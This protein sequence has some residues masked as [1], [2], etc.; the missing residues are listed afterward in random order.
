MNEQYISGH[1]IA[2]QFDLSNTTLRRW[3][4]E[5]KIRFLRT[6][7]GKGKRIYH[8]EDVKAIVGIPN[9]GIRFR[10]TICYARVSSTHQKEDLLRQ[11]ETLSKA[12]PQAEIVSDV[13]SGINFKRQGFTTLLQQCIKGDVERVVVTYRD[14]LCRF[15]VDLIEWLFD[16]YN[17][18]LVV[19]NP[20]EDTEHHEHTTSELAEDMLAITTFFVARNNGIRSA[21][22][23]KQ[24]QATCTEG[25]TTTSV[26]DP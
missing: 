26:S 10:K 6:K 16:Q 17:I 2:K 11:I 22:F 19:L 8:L 24:R 15:G 14:R 20:A 13:G 1:K 18:K 9:N 25:H 7:D 23:R 21:K 4:E 12:F 5:K 3:A